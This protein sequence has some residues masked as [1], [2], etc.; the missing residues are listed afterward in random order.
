MFVAAF[1]VLAAWFSFQA[2]YSSGKVGTEGT[3]AASSCKESFGRAP[4]GSHKSGS[5][6]DR[7]VTCDGTFRPAGGGAAVTSAK[8]T[9]TA[10]DAPAS[11]GDAY[12]RD[13]MDTGGKGAELH[14]TRL[15]PGSPLGSLLGEF[16]TSNPQK[17]GTSA[18]VALASLFLLAGGIFCLR[19]DWP[20]GGG[21]SVPLKVAWRESVGP[22]TRGTV[23]TLASAAVVGIVLVKIFV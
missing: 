22:G 7:Q 17:T 11:D 21:G 16:N 23:I 14:T 15:D 2:V 20:R 4:G 5:S 9:V 6:D 8:M 19:A 1:V 13:L 3:F 10:D 12:V 18:S